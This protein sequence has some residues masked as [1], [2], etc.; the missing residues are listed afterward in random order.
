MGFGNFFRR[1][2]YL[3]MDYIYGTLYRK[4]G[5]RPLDYP[6]VAASD[7]RL[8][9][10]ATSA[11]TCKPVYFT[12]DD[13]SQDHYDI[14]KASCSIPIVNRPYVIGGEPYYDGGVSDPIPFKKAFADGCSRVVVILTK[15]PVLEEGTE[16][17]KFVSNLIRR[18]FPAMVDGVR[19]QA[20]LYQ[21][22]LLELMQYVKEGKALIIAPESIY[23]MKTLTK[24]KAI[25]QKLYE[26]AY[27][28]AEQIPAFIQN[29]EE[30]R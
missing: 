23:G 29:T 4:D 2:S 13:L 9:V 27:K 6:A 22:Q 14:L 21:R 28:A 19:R 18:E 24:D 1:R 3:D 12:K 10:V 8:Y 25:L 30:G 16:S 17:R 20:M 7:M 15:P 26:D 5:E 11:S